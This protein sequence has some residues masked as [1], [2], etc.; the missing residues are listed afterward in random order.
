MEHSIKNRVIMYKI[1][2]NIVQLTHEP[3]VD[4]NIALE[5]SNFKDWKENIESD[6]NL[7]VRSIHFQSIDM[8]GPRV[9]FLK[10]G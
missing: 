9:G 2:G 1:N 3:S 7:Q 10:L 6:P 5:C 8:F 4:I